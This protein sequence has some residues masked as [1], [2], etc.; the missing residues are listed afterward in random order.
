[1]FRVKDIM[2]S[3]V[4]SVSPETEIVSAA[5]IMI[6]KRINGLPVVD[7][8]GKVVGILCQSDLVAQQKCVP[9]PSLFSLMDGF[10]PLTSLKRIEKEVE[11]IAALTVAQ[12][13][14]PKPATVTP[15]TGIEEVA[16][17][18]VDKGF[19]TL[20]VVQDGILVGVVGKEDVLKTLLPS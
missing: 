19:H 12:A 3:D 13:M 5:R 9:I 4:I 15:E 1:M 8:K 2:T 18:M 17:L 7:V 16:A 14:T 20:P 6:E 11:K 10:M